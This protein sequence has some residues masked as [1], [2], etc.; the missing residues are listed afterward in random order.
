MSLFG[1][2]KDFNFALN[3]IAY[4]VTLLDDKVEI[5]QRIGSKDPLTFFYSQIKS[6]K[7]I[8]EKEVSEKNKSI[9]YA[10]LGGVLLGGIGAVVGA[11]N[12]AGQHKTET[13][14][15]YEFVYDD[16]GEE[17]VIHLEIVGATLGLPN[18][19]KQLKEKCGF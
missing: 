9:K 8:I 13:K 12:G 15:Y 1:T 5:R 14:Y 16:N 6:H 3:G 17:K 7:M 10:V 19:E 4:K 2:K 18:M 11:V